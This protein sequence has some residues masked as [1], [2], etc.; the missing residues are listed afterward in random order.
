MRPGRVLLAYAL[1]VFVGGALLAPWLYWLAQWAASQTPAFASLARH[2]FHRYV[3]RS[4]LLLALL[5]LW[6]LL[7]GMGI[8]SWLEV[9]WTRPRGHGGEA[10]RG[11]VLGFVSLAMVVGCGLVAG[12]RGVRTDLQ[13]GPL[14]AKLI[15]AAATALL[16]AGLEET[17]FRGGIQGAWQ[18]AS[19]AGPALGWSS[20][21]YALVHFFQETRHPGPVH[22]YS[23]MEMLGQMLR[24]FADLQA[25]VPGFFTLL[26]AGLIL[27]L[28]YRRTGALYFS[29]GLHAGWIF[30]LKFT[31][32]V[33]PLR[34]EASP[35]L[36]GGRK[37]IDSWLAA[38]AL[39]LVF[40]AMRPWCPPASKTPASR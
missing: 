17:L 21:I 23:G 7:R 2:D 37:L 25:L 30:W 19:S 8:R 13:W 18:R 28:A 40:L 22:W 24:G 20:A 6:P 3:N 16:V 9:G 36:W 10:G 12:A 39:G 11:F 34:P 29:T 31:G 33:S 27:G 1:V 4:L 32:A 38:L 14:A 15:S 35:W 26:L 5:G